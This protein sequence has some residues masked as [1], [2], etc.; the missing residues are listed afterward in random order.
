MKTLEQICNKL[1]SFR[2]NNE[3]SERRH[4]M[5]LVLKQEHFSIFFEA[6]I[7]ST[8]ENVTLRP[9]Y[10]EIFSDSSVAA[11]RDVL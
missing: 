5:A 10:Y 1:N 8:I 6:A 7:L 9:F 11:T 3:I 2:A 4:L